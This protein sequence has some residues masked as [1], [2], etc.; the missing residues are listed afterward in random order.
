MVDNADDWDVVIGSRQTEGIA[1]YLP[2]SEEGVILFTTRAR[3]VAVS[4]TRGD[5]LKLGP[6]ERPDAV[7]SLEASLANDVVRNEATTNQLLD[8]LAY[9][10]DTRGTSIGIFTRRRSRTFDL[11]YTVRRYPTFIL[12][13]TYLLGQSLF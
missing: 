1:D 12:T 7:H 10:L 6:M 8:E 5:V 4:L 9:W 11:I 13:L 3:E 2:Q